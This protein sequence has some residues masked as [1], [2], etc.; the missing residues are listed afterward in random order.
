MRVR[1][2]RIRQSPVDADERIIVELRCI[3]CGSGLCG[4]FLTTPCP[5]CGHPCS[6]S[7]YGD[8][9]IYSESVEIE[10]LQEATRLVIYGG[11]VLAVVLAAGL[12]G[13]VATSTDVIDAARRTYETVFAVI[14]LYSVVSI[15]GIVLLTRR[16]SLAYYEAAYFHTR[17]LVR[18]G[19]VAVAALGA[20]AVA[21]HF[22]PEAVRMC[23]L[24]L[25]A[26]V[27]S[28]LFLRGVAK[29]MQRAPNIKLARFASRLQR[30][31]WA[32]GV[33]TVALG[34]AQR[35]SRTD[36]DW[37]GVLIALRVIAA[38][39]WITVGLAGYRLMTALRRTLAIIRQSI[40]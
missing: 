10:R 29:L 36:P 9:L 3:K 1:S 2:K 32:M 18:A 35:L 27:P 24:A 12:V 22:L 6:D 8:Y 31:V 33:L 7:V 23:L 28:A 16:C 30:A 5:Q 17:G 40:P 15:T 4:E 19:L 34:C 26:T 37:E 20:V 25:W 11:A 38:L 39:G 21:T 13:M 14:L